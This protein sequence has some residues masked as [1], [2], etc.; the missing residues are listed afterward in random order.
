MTGIESPHG[1]P[2][3]AALANDFD[4]RLFTAWNMSS[5]GCNAESSS[6]WNA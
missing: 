6:R 3:V 5:A 2:L 1:F 4:S